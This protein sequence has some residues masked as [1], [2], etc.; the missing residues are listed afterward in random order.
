MKKLVVFVLAVFIGVSSLAQVAYLQYRVVPA[1]RQQ[2]FVE[3]ET[4]YWAKVAQSAIDQGN[5]IG[6][7][8]WRKVG[9]TE[10]GAPNYVF[11]NLYEDTESID[12]GAVWSESNVQS[13]GVSPAMV[14]TNSFAPT[15]FDYWM[16]LEDMIEGEYQYAVVNYAMPDDVGAFIEENKTL[17]KPLHQQNITDGNNGMKSWGL[18]SVIHP[19]GK[20]GRFTVLTWDGFDKMSDVLN[21]LRY[22]G[23]GQAEGPWQDVISKSKM[24]EIMP[25]GFEYSIVYEK[26]MMIAPEGE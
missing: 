18:M 19:R 14:E 12:P 23:P 25:D 4:K 9:I 24:G 26:I 13:M 15:A 10:A 2:E 5:M 20:L 3:K 6:W 17:W 7:S 21:Y 1:E 16:Q 11:V 22:Q 8:L